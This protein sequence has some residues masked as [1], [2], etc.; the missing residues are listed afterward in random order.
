MPKNGEFAELPQYAVECEANSQGQIVMKLVV[1]FAM[2][3]HEFFLCTSKNYEQVARIIH[4]NI[5]DAGLEMKRAESGL[6]VA[7]GMPDGLRKPTQRG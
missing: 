7:K 4:K 1:M 5:M 3:R 6:V 2:A